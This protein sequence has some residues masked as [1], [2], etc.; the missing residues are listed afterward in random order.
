MSEKV[1]LLPKGFDNPDTKAAMAKTT[2]E[3]N[4][5]DY[6]CFQIFNEHEQLILTSLM[7]AAEKHIIDKEDAK[8]VRERIAATL[9]KRRELDNQLIGLISGRLDPASL[10]SQCDNHCAHCQGDNA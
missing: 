4:T 2:E 5:A 8:D 7:Y 6:E 3:R 1:T 9:A 10:P